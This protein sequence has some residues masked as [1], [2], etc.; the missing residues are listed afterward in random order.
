MYLIAPNSHRYTLF[1]F[2]SIDYLQKIRK[3]DK[4]LRLFKFAMGM[5]RLTSTTA[6]KLLKF[7]FVGLKIFFV[8]FSILVW[9][10]LN[11]PKCS[12]FHAL[13]NGIPYLTSI[14]KITP[15]KSD[16]RTKNRKFG[17]FWPK[18]RP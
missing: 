9:T 17:Q 12:L 4:K 11:I 16:K 2:N 3:N 6:A 10:C 14:P 5:L 8:I 18:F 15:K 13:S 1:G 7:C